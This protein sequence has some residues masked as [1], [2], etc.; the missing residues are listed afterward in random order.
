[1]KVGLAVSVCSF[2]LFTLVNLISWKSSEEVGRLMW[3][4]SSKVGGLLRRAA[5]G[6]FP[7]LSIS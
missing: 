7:L 5:W 2:V 6:G 3:F 4:V 1:M